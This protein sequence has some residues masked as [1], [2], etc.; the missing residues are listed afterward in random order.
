VSDNYRFHHY[1]GEFAGDSAVLTFIQSNKWDTNDDGTGDPRAGMS[2]YDT[3]A[4]KYKTYIGSSPS[5]IDITN[6]WNRSGTVISPRTSGDT[7]QAGDGA[8][9]SPSYSFSSDPDTGIYYIGAGNVGFSSGGGTVSDFDSD[10]MHYRDDKRIFWGSSDDAFIGWNDAN[11]TGAALFLCTPYNTPIVITDTNR[12]N[13]DLSPANPGSPSLLIHSGNEDATQWFR[14]RHNGT[15]AY[16]EC[17]AGTGRYRFTGATLYAGSAFEAYHGANAYVSTTTTGFQIRNSNSAGR[18]EMFFQNDTGWPGQ[19]GFTLHGT[20]SSGS[21]GAWY[22]NRVNLYTFST[23]VGI[24]LVA[25]GSSQTISISAGGYNPRQIV[26]YAATNHVEIG[27]G[28]SASHS[29]MLFVHG[30][31]ELDNILYTSNVILSSNGSNSDPTYSF[32]DDTDTGM[33]RVG[34][35]NLGFSVGGSLLFDINSTRALSAVD[36]DLNNAKK[37]INLVDPALA[38]DAATKAYVDSQVQG[39]EWQDSVLDKDLSAEPGSPATGARYII[40]DGTSSPQ[41]IVAVNQGSKTF[42]IAGNYSA[43]LAATDIIRISQSTANDTWYTVVS[44]T[45]NDPNTD[46]VVSE[47]IPSSTADGKMHWATTGDS[48]AQDSGSGPGTIAEYDGSSWDYTRPEEGYALWVVDEDA[49]YVFNGV[50][51]WAKFGS[52]IDHGS[53]QGLGDDDHTQYALLSG[54]SGGQTLYG[55]TGSG[56][57]LTLSS[58]SHATAGTIYLNGSTIELGTSAILQVYD[59]IQ[60]AAG[61]NLGINSN[62]TLDLVSSGSISVNGSGVDFTSGSTVTANS[63][64][65]TSGIAWDIE[66][67]P[68]SEGAPVVLRLTA[69]TDTRWN[70]GAC[71]DLVSEDASAYLL[72]GY[73]N[74]TL[75]LYIDRNANII[76]DGSS[77]DLT[78]GARSATITLNESGETSLD[79][80]FTASSIIGALN[81]LKGAIP[82]VYWERSGTILSPDTDG[83]TLQVGDGSAANPGYAFE[84]TED[85][86]LWWDSG[87]SRVTLSTNT[88]SESIYID[89]AH[90]VSIHGN[91]ITIQSLGDALQSGDVFL[92]ARGSGTVGDETSLYVRAYKNGSSEDAVVY[93][94]AET[95]L[96]IGT[97]AGGAATYDEPVNI[98]TTSTSSARTVTVGEGDLT[99]NRGSTTFVN[100]RTVQVSAIAKDGSSGNQSVTVVATGASGHTGTLSVYVEASQ[101]GGSGDAKVFV[102]ADTEINIG[103][104]QGGDADLN[105]GSSSTSS[106]RTILVGEM[107]AVNNR[108]STVQIL[109][110]DSRLIAQGDSSTSSPL[111]A[112]VSSE[113]AN[114]QT[115]NAFLYAKN[116]GAGSGNLYVDATT[117]LNIG[118]TG[119][120]DFDADINIGTATDSAARTIIIGEWDS[121]ANRGSLISLQ[122]YDVRATAVGDAST[123]SSLT[124]VLS[125]DSVNA[126][127]ANVQVYA[128]NTSGAGN[129]YLE[130]TTVIDIGNNGGADLDADINI[131]TNSNSS[132]RTVTVG[133]QGTRAS[134]IDVKSDETTFTFD[135]FLSIEDQV[136][137]PKNG[138]ELKTMLT[139]A[140][141]MIIVLLP[142]V[143][144]DLEDS[145]TLG[146][147]KSIFGPGTINFNTD[148]TSN[149]LN[150]AHPLAVT[151]VL[152]TTTT[153]ESVPSVTTAG[154]IRFAA[155]AENSRLSNCAFDFNTGDASSFNSVYTS[156]DKV[157]VEN[158]LFLN[159]SESATGSLIKISSCEHVRITGNRCYQNA[160]NSWPGVQCKYIVYATGAERCQITENV[161]EAGD[162]TSYSNASCQI[163]LDAS[164]KRFSVTDNEF[165]NSEG[166]SDS[167]IYMA[168]ATS[169]VFHGHRIS[170]N[171]F[172]AFRTNSGS[173]DW[174]SNNHLVLIDHGNV[175]FVGNTLEGEYIAYDTAYTG[176]FIY[177][178]SEADMCVVMGNNINGGATSQRGIWVGGKSGEGNNPARANITGNTIGGFNPSG[179]GG[180]YGILVDNPDGDTNGADGGVISS[181]TIIVA[182]GET[183]ISGKITAGT[184]AKPR[185]WVI[186]GNTC[187]TG[188][189]KIDVTS[190]DYSTIIGNADDTTSFQ[191]STTG[192]NTNN[193]YGTSNTAEATGANH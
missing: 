23:A 158:C 171:C 18:A 27:Y 92:E 111:T 139:T 138:A 108:G 82:T 161:F 102:D 187:Y 184:G 2:Y 151:D 77:Q 165:E 190:F 16:V 96:N 116:S 53:L 62:G 79:G 70:G 10:G 78:L 25:D 112:L 51:V 66:V 54:R 89:S 164:T 155:G 22:A 193:Q 58:T 115:A 134:T 144:Y 133:E 122:G 135:S 185:Y 170:N 175:S 125:A 46:I 172:K 145:I 93:V 101:S 26:V 64:S 9:G 103:T 20:A 32:T 47:S 110:I 73:S 169:N 186:V 162:Q 106:A 107:D 160:T 91:S 149:Y 31:A 60:N 97:S 74:T 150:C 136:Y 1:M 121:V 132:A 163:Y 148:S 167:F 65:I 124:A 5:W 69:G 50:F 176:S 98:G 159:T 67:N 113:S 80:G 100:G 61:Q 63:Y 182:S 140:T 173:Y 127:A 12:W 130:A 117:T 95:A 114:A 55:G 90:T 4:D 157:T 189:T 3:D 13:F 57:D 68:S 99:A 14:L 59:T 49:L 105:I 39:L 28:G 45:W 15:D 179:T 137:V 75:T 17:G 86:G 84:S 153:R 181:N 109:G 43:S 76:A 126:Q 129:L 72:R 152:F 154:F 44:A 52:T 128:K 34:S 42:S 168:E 156:C 94:N 131:G 8:V 118:A 88:A 19:G 36:I 174:D 180:G 178:G 21:W 83:D 40:G 30:V 119:N 35:D 56:D 166:T 24:G 123:S 146:E 87:N 141:P 104:N 143:T 142:N 85:A 7:I 81:E 41:D 183:C 188:T 71:L 29:P 11:Q 6:H 192:S 37:V 48:W 147:T 191:G 177:L 33:Y 120:A 38:Q